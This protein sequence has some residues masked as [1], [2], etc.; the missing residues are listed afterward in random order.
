MMKSRGMKWAGHLAREGEKRY[1]QRVVMGKPEGKRPLGG[2]RCK[3]QG[4]I[5][6]YLYEIGKGQVL[7]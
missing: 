7:D 4:N 3:W 6:M 5:T 2:P 1:V